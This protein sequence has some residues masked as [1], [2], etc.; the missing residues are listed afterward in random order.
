MSEDAQVDEQ[1]VDDGLDDLIDDT[2]TDSTEAETSGDTSERGETAADGTVAPDTSTGPDGEE[3]N[4]EGAADDGAQ[5]KTLTEGK[6][7]ETFKYKDKEYSYEDFLKDED[8]RN[9]LVTSANQ[10]SHYQELYGQSKAQF[11]A[12]QNQINVLMQSQQQLSRPQ[13]QGGPPRPMI[14]PEKVGLAYKDATKE[15][16][17]EGWIDEDFAELY[18]STVASM[19]FIRDMVLGRLGSTEAAVEAVMSSRAGE[20]RHT[21]E[22]TR[23]QRMHSIF[24][25]LASE[26]GIFAPLKEQKTREEFLVAVGQS[27]NP[28]VDLLLSDPQVLRRLWIAQNHEAMIAAA[29]A[30]QRRAE[31]EAAEKRRL[32]V[33]EGTGTRAG[34][35]RPNPPVL[36]G[37]EEGWADLSNDW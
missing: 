36:P 15:F 34:G 16:V 9:K 31:Q 17:K 32:A 7:K 35:Q 23:W 13:E 25:G 29:T 5:D 6:K 3:K 26:G 24:D 14:T 4:A 28:E 18:P 10:Q 20:I 1:K 8:L 21:Q 12:L 19:V 30:A 11:E 33:G 22:Q 2:P 37:T 27:L